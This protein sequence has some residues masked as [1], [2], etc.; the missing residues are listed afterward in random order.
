MK[1]TPVALAGTD[2][3]AI[4]V[5]FP[6]T[7]K[8]AVAGNKYAARLAPLSSWNSVT[9]VKSRSSVTKIAGAPGVTGGFTPGVKIDVK[10]ILVA[11]PGAAP[12][13]DGVR[14]VRNAA[15]RMAARNPSPPAFRVMW[16]YLAEV[17]PSPTTDGKDTFPFQV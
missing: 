10:T 9:A 3:V 17:K 4:G 2:L 7:Y 11:S 1:V 12:A 15:I 5:G 13:G 14:A 6:S 8:V 16:V